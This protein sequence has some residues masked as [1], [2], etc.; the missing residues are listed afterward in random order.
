[1]T[2]LA[3]AA[4]AACSVGAL[5]P[6]FREALVEPGAEGVPT[7]HLDG[8]LQTIPLP[9]LVVAKPMEHAD[10]GFGDVQHLFDGQELVEHVP[11]NRQDGCA[12]A[13]G[14]AEAFATVLNP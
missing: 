2:G 1:M 4:A 8:E 13:D 10:H 11:R 6:E 5:G 9:M 3:D 14:D 12:T 7:H